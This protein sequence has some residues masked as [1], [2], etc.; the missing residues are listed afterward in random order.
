MAHP[1]ISISSLKSIKLLYSLPKEQKP[2]ELR[3]LLN[4]FKNELKDVGIVNYKQNTI[5]IAKNK[6]SLPEEYVNNISTRI[7]YTHLQC[8]ID[9]SNQ[10][11]FYIEVP[12]GMYK[13]DKQ[14]RIGININI[15]LLSNLPENQPFTS[16]KHGLV[17]IGDTLYLMPQANETY[18]IRN[19]KL[20]Y[21]RN[22]KYIFL[23]P[24]SKQHIFIY[25][26]PI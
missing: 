5:S 1:S 17:L 25:S 8:K 6:N 10:K 21:S 24:E 14:V 2:K 13:P 26:V 12:Q 23:H 19:S 18:V 7:Q 11:E 15:N 20:Y 9:D 22:K 16:D 3:A 4:L